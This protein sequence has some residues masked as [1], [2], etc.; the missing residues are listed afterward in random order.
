MKQD[1]V[2]NILLS[3]KAD[4][5]KELASLGRVLDKNTGDWIVN[6]ILGDGDRA[7]DLDNAN[8]TEEYEENVAVFS[9]LEERY[10]QI[11]KAL[12]ALEE[13]TYGICEVEGCPISKERLEANPAATTCIKHAA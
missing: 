12:A 11:N 5:E 1:D 13:G 10:G 4:L 3:K 8:L 7:D 6:P 2:K 9:V